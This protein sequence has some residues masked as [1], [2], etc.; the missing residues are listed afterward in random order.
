MGVSTSVSLFRRA[1]GA[2]GRDRFSLREPEHF[3]HLTRGA[4]FRGDLRSSIS[5]GGRGLASSS[6]NGVLFGTA[7]ASRS[8]R[9]SFLV[10]Q[11]AESARGRSLRPRTLARS[12]AS[13]RPFLLRLWYASTPASCRFD[14]QPCPSCRRSSCRLRRAFSSLVNVEA[15]PRAF[16][17]GRG[18]PRRASG[19]SARNDAFARPG[20][21][22]RSACI[23]FA[24]L[25]GA[26]LGL[27]WREFS[28]DDHRSRDSAALAA[29]PLH[30]KERRVPGH[31]ELAAPIARTSCVHVRRRI[32]R[33]RSRSVSG[34]SGEPV[35]RTRSPA[36]KP[37]RAQGWRAAATAQL[38]RFR[39]SFSRSKSAFELA[40]AS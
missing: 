20:F 19:I 1:R 29:I 25:V 2:R 13:Q 34:A 7:V 15:A 26:R 37:Y 18:T 24:A 11:L 4:S 22:C 33:R 12:S 5:F 31:R 14:R 16:R 3:Y 36:V 40:R 38:R 28:R 6:Q 23:S 27:N 35:R 8:S 32:R 17:Q 9:A 39:L 30:V 10:G 21:L